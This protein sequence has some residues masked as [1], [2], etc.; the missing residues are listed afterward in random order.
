MDRRAFFAATMAIL[1]FAGV[2]KTEPDLRKVWRHRGLSWRQHGLAWQEVRMKDL[3]VGDLVMIEDLPGAMRVTH[4]P[5]LTED[6]VW[7]I[8]TEPA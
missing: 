2:V 8:M 3:V 6:G 4:Q 7:G 5:K 1:G